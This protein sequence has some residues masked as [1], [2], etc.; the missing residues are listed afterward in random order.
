VILLGLAH[1]TLLATAH[2]AERPGCGF[3]GLQASLAVTPRAPPPPP[4]AVLSERDAF[5]TFPHEASSDHFVMK[6]GDSVRVDEDDIQTSLVALELAWTTEID[7]MGHPAP[8]TTDAYRMN[9]YVGDSD[10]AAPDSYGAAGYYNRDPEGFPFLMLAPATLGS[11]YEATTTAHEFYHAIQD[12][13]GAYTYSGDDAWFWE[14]SAMWIE[15][16][17]YPDDPDYFTFLFG[18]ALLPHLSVVSFDYPDT[19]ALPEYHQYGAMILPRYCSEVL[20]EATLVR[21][22]WIDPG[23]A[24]TPLEALL[25]G[26]AARGYDPASEMA[27]FAAHM[28]AYDFEDGAAMSR[29]VEGQE[30]AFSSTAEPLA[31]TVDGVTD[32]AVDAA[33][34]V[35]AYGYEVVAWNHAASGPFRVTVTGDAT[36]DAGA[37]GTW[38]FTLVRERA[39]GPVYDPIVGAGDGGPGG[40]VDVDLTSED[41]SAWIVAAVTTDAVLE[42]SLTAHTFRWS[43]AVEERVDVDTAGDPPGDSGGG[44]EDE[45]PAL[46]CGCASGGGAAGTLWPMAVGSAILLALRAAVPTPARARPA[47][48]RSRWPRRPLRG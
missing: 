35:Q 23:D 13:T 30:R 15:G 41:R 38:G 18:F 11:S 25:L 4:A 44:P 8:P 9:V 48:P 22:A 26:L 33:E 16:E 40:V 28:A 20:G 7:T 10:P 27:T 2:A 12:G 45:T 29:A 42:P 21:D 5:G 39:D 3:P 43:Y 34:P 24:R 1:A 6:W 37:D 31:G 47:A 19:G 14:A 32:G 46:A 17:V 36:S